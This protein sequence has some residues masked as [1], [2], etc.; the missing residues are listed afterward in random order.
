MLG[1]FLLEVRQAR[2]LTQAEVAAVSGIPQPNLSAFE[3]GRRMPSAANMHRILDACGFELTARAGQTVVRARPPALGD[4]QVDDLIEDLIDDVR[5]GEPPEQL[6]PQERAVRL[7]A[8]LRLAGRTVRAR[9]E[10][11]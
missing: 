7:G 4:R 8:A 1:T 2:G 6:T 3:R 10:R 5:H 9:G 11:R